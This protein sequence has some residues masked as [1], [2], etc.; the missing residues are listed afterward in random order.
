MTTTCEKV[1]DLAPGF[2]LGALEPDE[3]IAIREHLASCDKP[4]PEI[5]ELGG[6][7][8]YL[9]QLVE[10]VEPPEAL[11]SSILSA[12]RADISE[13]QRRDKAAERLVAALGTA[14]TAGAAA[15]RPARRRVPPEV[16]DEPPATVTASAPESAAAA[17]PEPVVAAPA[18]NVVSLQ[19]TRARRWRVARWIA[20]AAAVVAIAASTGWAVSLQQQLADAQA[21]L[22]ARASILQGGP[23]D[24]PVITL[25]SPAGAS[26]NG[27]GRVRANGHLVLGL[28]DLP[29]AG[30]GEVYVVWLV[31][32]SGAPV[33][34]AVIE[35]P[36]GGLAQ[37]DIDSPAVGT[38][39]EVWVTRE[40]S[41]DVKA[42]TTAPILKGTLV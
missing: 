27:Q 32:D 22:R 18:T 16:A 3:M 40:R 13:R 29:P 33:P 17:A 4:H 7:V 35:A 23:Q 26:V 30:A 1:R 10:P 25:T 20:A 41:K 15:A 2:V 39:A 19:A 12:V 11:K 8:P 5:R 9:A 6:V 36:N 14:G 34:G 38:A 24:R 37:V 28:F 42:P 31:P 21:E